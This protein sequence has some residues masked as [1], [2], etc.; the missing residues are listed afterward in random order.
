M[1][2]ND[3][4]D[5]MAAL[6]INH[7]PFDWRIFIDLSKLSLKAVLLHKERMKS[8]IPINYAAHMRNQ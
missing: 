1:T 5:L 6:N 3:I 7:D 4:S 8:L 2:C